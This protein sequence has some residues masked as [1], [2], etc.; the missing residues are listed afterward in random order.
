MPTVVA[1]AATVVLAL[2]FVSGGQTTSAVAKRLTGHWR[3]LSYVNISEKGDERPGQYDAGRITYDEHGNMAAQ[4]MRS[5][6]TRLSSPPTDGERAAA[7]SGFLGYYGRYVIDEA[8]GS[9]TH[10][11]EGSSNPNWIKTA[12]VRYYSFS[13]D[14]NRLTLSIRNGDRVT[15]R[16]VWERLK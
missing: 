16:L 13:E 2:P 11:V 7:Y 5:D 6:R 4:L 14:G 12:Q 3:M 10:H 8:K 9:V 15:G 1:L